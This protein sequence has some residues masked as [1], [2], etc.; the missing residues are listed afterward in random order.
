[1]WQPNKLEQERL[2]KVQRL[3][4]TAVQPYPPRVQRTHS[5]VQAIAAQELY[6][7]QHPN[8]ESAPPAPT[9]MVCGRVRRVNLKGKVSFM[10][11]E[12]ESGRVQLFLR[13]N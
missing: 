3:E 2:D 5:A 6:E 1:M 9:V 12:D 10:H 13:V 4:A 7:A 8:P 11:I